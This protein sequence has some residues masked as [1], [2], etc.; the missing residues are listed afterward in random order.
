[1][2]RNATIDRDFGDGEHCFRIAIG[3]LREL[4][5]K[6]GASPFAALARM[7]AWTPMVDD[8]RETIRLGLV[9]GGMKPTD[10]LALV[11]TYVDERPLAESLPDAIL[12]LQAALMGVP[13]E[14]P[15]KSQGET[16]A[17]TTPPTTG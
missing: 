15:G 9:G 3:Q 13:D 8:I 16:P 6:V 2:S 5:E 7:I 14:T 4:Q 12:I 1:M 10:A 11:R 17:P